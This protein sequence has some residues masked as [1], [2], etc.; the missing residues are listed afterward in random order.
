MSRS[1]DPRLDSLDVVPSPNDE[2]E[3]GV[4]TLTIPPRLP[5]PTVSIRMKSFPGSM[6]FP[7]S[8]VNGKGP[9]C[10]GCGL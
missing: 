3:I 1:R 9:R 4:R 8:M 6:T 10:P 5:H 2:H 7:T